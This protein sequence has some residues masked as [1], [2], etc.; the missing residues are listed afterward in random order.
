MIDYTMYCKPVDVHTFI[1]VGK[2]N[3][4]KIIKNLELDILNMT[5][6][7]NSLDYRTNVKGKFTGWESL[8]D[9]IWLNQFLNEN[10]GFAFRLYGKPI[11]F[12]L[13][14]SWGNLCEKEEDEV[15]EHRHIPTDCFCGILYFDDY[16]PGTTFPEYDLTVREE[17]GRFVFFHPQLLH[18]VEKFNYQKPRI[19]CAFNCDFLREW[20]E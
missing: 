17:R 12:T 6:K 16:G 20:D 2:Y 15:K 5:K 7:E 10:L 13:K 3:N 18:R 1:L 8:N 9:N 4:E 19:T 14:S 11:K